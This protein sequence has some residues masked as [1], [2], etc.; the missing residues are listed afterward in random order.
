MDQMETVVTE[1]RA[2][3]ESSAE[4]LKEAETLLQVRHTLHEA[5]HGHVVYFSSDKVICPGR[6]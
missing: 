5:H 6:G 3:L 4:Q 2:Q 1:L